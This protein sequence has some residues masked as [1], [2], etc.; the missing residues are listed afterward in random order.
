[1][2][3]LFLLIPIYF[4][5][6]TSCHEHENVPSVP[7]INLSQMDTT[8]LASQDFFQF[9]NGTWLKNTEIPADRSRWGSFDELRKKSSENVL[10]VLSEAMESDK[11]SAGTD[12]HKAVTFYKTAMD[13]IQINKMGLSP[14]SP[15]LKEIENISTTEEVQAYNEKMTPYGNRTFFDFAIF[16]DLKNSTIN[17][18]YLTSG[19]IGLP[20][21]EYYTGDDEDSIEKR[22]KYIQHIIRM[23][24]HLGIEGNIAA[25]K[26]KNI[27]MLETKLATAMMTKEMR[28]NPLNIYNKVSISDLSESIPTIDWI[29]YLKNIGVGTLDSIII[30][31]SKYFGDLENALTGSD[32]ETIKDY[33]VWNELNNAASFLS[34]EIEADDFEFYGKELS[35][36]EQMRPRWESVLDMAN[37]SIG[38]AIGKLYVDQYFPPE[39]KEKA[40]NMVDNIL[41]SFENRIKGLEWMTDDTKVRALEKLNSF[42][43]KIGYPDKWKD[44]GSLDIKSVKDGGS[45]ISN[46]MEVLK[47]NYEDNL[48]KLG[49]DVDK[50]EWGMS[51]QTVNAYYNPLNNEIVF[52]AAIL[53]PPFYN[54]QADEAVNYGGIGGVIGHEISHGFDDQGSRFDANGNMVN[55]WSEMDREQFDERN[56]VL[57]DQFNA[58][59]PLPNIF[60]NGKFTLGENIGDLGGISVAYDGLMQHLKENGKPD[61]IDGYSAEQRF[62]LSWGT[63][64][65][66]KM[67]DAE[68][69]N[70]IKT[71]P[72]APGMYR[73]IGPI[74]NMEEFYNAFD[75]KEGDPMWRPDSLRVNIW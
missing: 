32:I 24:R 75:V 67:R 15:F 62:F 44:Y 37:G 25:Q 50:T 54:Y 38:E 65:R 57:I 6:L 61:L 56:Q 53:Q 26:A 52:P 18:P 36:S 4:V 34:Q 7:G 59:E 41:N 31:D 8:I 10:S 74:S 63:I 64:W 70:R 20:E 72:H 68:I 46:M 71:D 17:A 27:M 14:I 12:Q 60:V 55:W 19:S 42:T 28:R 33:M 39:A 9:V 51:P 29:A 1:M 40:N 66:T 69:K 13:T 47:W 22:E 3:K 73:A 2:K 35:G 45:Y 21:K 5:I 11:Y 30:T 58:Y 43:V 16:P 49:K 23:F 48:K